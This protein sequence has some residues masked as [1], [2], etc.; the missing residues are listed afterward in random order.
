ML[1]RKLRLVNRNRC[2]HNFKTAKSCVILFDS[3]DPE[4]FRSLREFAKHLEKEGLETRITGYIDKDVVPNE[5]LLWDNC[6][7]LCRKDLD[8]FF[9]PGNGYAEQ[10]LS[11]KHDI[12]ID[13]CL[14]N[15]FPLEYLSSLSD[16]SFKVGRYRETGPE[17][18][19]MIHIEK[20]NRV[21]YLI[22]QITR[23]I[24]LLNQSAE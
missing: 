8:W 2:F 4:S 22:E 9:R 13:L 14:G 5:M 19:M 23:Y 17:L 12:L 20:D 16:A 6:H 11:Y 21:I 15:H 10:F 1:R 18:D 7:I 24:S 3:V